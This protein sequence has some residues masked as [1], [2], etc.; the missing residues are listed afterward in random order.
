MKILIASN[1]FP[2]PPNFGGVYDILGRIKELRAQGH[3]IDIVYS[4]KETV[5]ESYLE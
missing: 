4:E 5:S 1:F 2:Y 3:S